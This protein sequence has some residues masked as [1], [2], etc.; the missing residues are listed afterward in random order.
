MA[1]QIGGRLQSE[2][3][4]AK[5][6]RQKQRSKT[7]LK[8]PAPFLT[9]GDVCPASVEGAAMANSNAA[10]TNSVIRS[11]RSASKQNET[12]NLNKAPKPLQEFPSPCAKHQKLRSIRG[13]N[14]CHRCLE[15]SRILVRCSGKWYGGIEVFNHS[16]SCGVGRN[17]QFRSGPESAPFREINRLKDE[18]GFKICTAEGRAKYAALPSRPQKAPWLML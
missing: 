8:R 13:T 2:C 7:A 5:R 10:Q 17:D 3:P 16:N 14:G 15:L 1:V 11:M 4:V 9:V 12:H 6:R 18:H